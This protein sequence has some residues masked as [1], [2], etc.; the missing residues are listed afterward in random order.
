MTTSRTDQSKS[1]VGGNQVA[2]DFYENNEIHNHYRAGRGN[3]INLLLRKLIKEYEENIVTKEFVSSLQF[4][5]RNPKVS[6]ESSL[7][8]KLE[9]SRADI[10][11]EDAILEKEFFAKLMEEFKHFSSAQEIFAYFLSMI[12]N[13]FYSKIIPKSDDLTWSEIQEIV[14]ECIVDKILAE[15]GEGSDVFV[16][17]P[18]HIRGMV[19][20][21]A[22]RCFVRWKK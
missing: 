3:Q 5:V 13:V 7:K 17:N 2:R 10:S 18:L 8:E 6:E 14:D 22:D 20:W 16:I 21:L 12:Y 19:F 11:Y 9:K 15:I 1:T 4:Y